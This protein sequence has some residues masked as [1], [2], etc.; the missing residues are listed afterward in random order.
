M[1]NNYNENLTLIINNI[2][3]PWY[4]GGFL[5]IHPDL[6]LSSTFG[7]IDTGEL[8]FVFGFGVMGED[9]PVLLIV[10]DDLLGMSYLGT[11]GLLGLVAG[12]PK[13]T[14]LFGHH[15]GSAITALDPTMDQVLR[16][17]LV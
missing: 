1:M 12:I 11:R 14:I 4:L 16:S 15:I 9:G 8:C 3:Y 7:G 5:M 6:V 13:D 17:L 10:F 2:F